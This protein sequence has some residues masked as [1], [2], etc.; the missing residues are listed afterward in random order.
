MGKWLK[1]DNLSRWIGSWSLQTKVAAVQSVHQAAL[2]KAPKD[3]QGGRNLPWGWFSSVGVQE[4]YLGGGL[5]LQQR[6]EVLQ[7]QNPLISLSFQNLPLLLLG[8]CRTMKNSPQSWRL[9]TMTIRTFP[10]TVAIFFSFP[11]WLL[12]RLLPL[13]Y[14]NYSFKFF[15]YDN[16]KNHRVGFI[17]II[18]P[19]HRWKMSK[20]P[21]ALF[22]LK[23]SQIYM[24]FRKQISN[25][26]KQS[27]TFLNET[28][29]DHRLHGSYSDLQ[30]P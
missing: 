15:V 6:F 13:T 10:L 2:L 27:N 21:L 1:R 23:D 4:M 19:S 7:F 22:W 12:K 14:M 16:K 20:V 29:E 11:T 3:S 18:F 8:L 17:V 24:P 28:N 26:V 25:G 5:T 30:K 9:S